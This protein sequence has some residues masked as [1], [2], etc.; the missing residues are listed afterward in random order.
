MGGGGENQHVLNREINGVVKVYSITTKSC[1]N[2]FADLRVYRWAQF[3]LLDICSYK[4]AF[5]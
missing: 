3:E 5:C 2:E 1:E 4:V